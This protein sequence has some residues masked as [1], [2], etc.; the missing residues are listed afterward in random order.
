MKKI[1]VGKAYKTRDGKQVRIHSVDG[2][3]VHGIH[4]DVFD[5]G[6]EWFFTTWL[7]DGSYLEEGGSHD[8]DI[9]ITGLEVKYTLE[10]TT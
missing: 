5:G 7:K 4:G 2:F 10:E 9:V 6:N 1:E 8:W 3:G